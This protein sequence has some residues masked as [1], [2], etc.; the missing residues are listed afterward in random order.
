M[1]S[2]SFQYAIFPVFLLFVVISGHQAT[3]VIKSYA[4][5]LFWIQ[6]W[7]PLYAV[8]NFII[9]MYS[10]S[11]IHQWQRRRRPGD[12]ADEFPEYRDH[13]RPGDCRD[14]GDL[15]P[16]HC[17][18]HRQGRRGRPA[19]RRRSGGTAPRP[20]ENRQRLA[21]GNMQMG[22][23]SLNNASHDTHAR[24]DGGHESEPA[25]GHDQLS[26]ARGL[27]L[28][29]LSLAAA[30]SSNQAKSDVRADMAL[31]DSLGAAAKENYERSQQATQQ[32]SSEYAESALAA[33]KQEAGFERA[34]PRQQ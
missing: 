30:L 12:R 22:N 9:T 16:G 31:N 7:A 2:N 19:G 34:T 10:R 32:H 11:P 15:D 8:M 5:S 14:A 20:G 21:M 1:P 29:P 3:G 26:G 4:A 18:G 6:L 28:Q 24:A 23:A 27:R 17:R 33:L 13:Q 25:A